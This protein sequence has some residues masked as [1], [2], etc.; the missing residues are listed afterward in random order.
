MDAH[1]SAPVQYN[2]ERLRRLGRPQ[3]PC[4]V[5]GGV[6]H[7]RVRDHCHAHGWIRGVLCNYCN[8]LMMAVDR[9]ASPAPTYLR[10]PL[11]GYLTHWHKCPDCRAV[12]W[13]ESAYCACD[14]ADPPKSTYECAEPLGVRPCPWTGTGFRPPVT[15]R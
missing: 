12:G 9:G 2:R 4:E 11:A 6:D 10:A 14:H 3:E 8:G 7:P 13:T 15:G 1:E 5:C